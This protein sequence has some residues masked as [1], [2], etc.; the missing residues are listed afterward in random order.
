VLRIKVIKELLN[1][2]AKVN[3]QTNYGE[4]AYDLAK[5][6]EIK[7]LLKNSHLL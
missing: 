7:N 5:T 2:N 1:K 3:L 4:T 6:D